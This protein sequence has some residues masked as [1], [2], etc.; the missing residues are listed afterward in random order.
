M[1]EDALSGIK[2]SLAL[3]GFELTYNVKENVIDIFVKAGPA[4]C[5]ECLVPE[6]VLK[7]MIVRELIEHEVMYERINVHIINVHIP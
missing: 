1:I 3:D 6:G 2:K 7:R 4:A 5:T